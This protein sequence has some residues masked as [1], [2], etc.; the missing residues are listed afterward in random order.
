MSRKFNKRETET[1]IIRKG[2][3]DEKKEREKEK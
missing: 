1:D 2:Q 3:E